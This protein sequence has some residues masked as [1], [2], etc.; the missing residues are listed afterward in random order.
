MLLRL[1]GPISFLQCWPL[2]SNCQRSWALAEYNPTASST[3][4]WPQNLESAVDFWQIRLG[5]PHKFFLSILF[6]LNSCSLFYYY[7]LLL[8]WCCY[9]LAFYFF[10]FSQLGLTYSFLSVHY[11]LSFKH[12]QT[13]FSSIWSTI[14]VKRILSFWFLSFYIFLLI[15]LNILISTILYLWICC[16]LL[17]Q[18][19]LP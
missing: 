7:L 10:S 9:F 6:Y 14:T 5:W 13:I 16:H 4:P 1:S 8:L 11:L 19:F 18:H 15:H 12:D 3:K 17:A 2:M